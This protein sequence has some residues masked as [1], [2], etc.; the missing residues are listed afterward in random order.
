LAWDDYSTDSSMPTRVPHNLSTTVSEF[1]ESGTLL[2]GNVLWR[3]AGLTID[4]GYSEFTNQGSFEFDME[5]AFVRV[6]MDVTDHW[7]AAAE[8]ES[9]DYAEKILDLAHYDSSRIGVFL[10]WHR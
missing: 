6:A 8:F 5:R 2:E 9:Q 3:I 4:L 7:A 1:N 10:R